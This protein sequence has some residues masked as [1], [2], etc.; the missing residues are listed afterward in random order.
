MTLAKNRF[1]NLL[2]LL[3]V[4][5]VGAAIFGTTD[6]ACAAFRV[7]INAT[8]GSTE[9]FYASSS[10]SATFTN[11][12]IGNISA[13]INTDSSNYPGSSAI[14][15]L[16]QTLIIGTVDGGAGTTSN[17]DVQLDVIQS[18]SG[19]SDGQITDSTQITNLNNASL[20]TFT[21][22]KG[23]PLDASSDVSVATNQTVTAGSTVNTTTVNG[24]SF[25]SLSSTLNP[26]QNERMQHLSFN[27][28]SG[29]TLSNHL[30]VTG[31]NAGAT[32]TSLTAV[33]GVTA[34]PAP[35]GLVLLVSAA[36]ALALG[37]WRRRRK[38]RAEN[39]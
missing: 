26:A 17:I 18:V 6:R 24:T 19:L 23:N 27:G 25:D 9:Y 29:Y 20:L 10:T 3:A 30:I 2:R 5:L 36:P 8:G 7:T 38:A 22:P 31:I 4:L 12:T 39:A 11:I 13:T 34:V 37:W 32:G 33:S 28:S 15:S 16:S 35:A 14:G 21:A 1:R